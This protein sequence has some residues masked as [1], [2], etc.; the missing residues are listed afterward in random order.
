MPFGRKRK[1]KYGD[2]G[3]IKMTLDIMKE[4]RSLKKGGGTKKQVKSYNLRQKERRKEL[5]VPR[6]ER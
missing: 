5:F 1:K 6:S 3:E 4:R 2:R